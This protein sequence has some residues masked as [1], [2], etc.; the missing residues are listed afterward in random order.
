MAEYRL[1]K[2]IDLSDFKQYLG[3]DYYVSVKGVVYSSKYK[4]IL[5]GNLSNGY[6][7]FELLVN[8]KKV[9]KSQHRLIAE[10]F[11]PNP[12]N[13][14]LV[15]HLNDI[16]SDV[17]IKNLAWGTKSDNMK[18][19]VMNGLLKNRPSPRG[20]KNRNAKLNES[21]VVSIRNELNNGF[22]LSDIS[23]KYGVSWAVAYQIKNRLTW[24]HI[25]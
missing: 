16:K 1:L 11:I 3:S 8:G 2:D 14:P 7:W 24:K 4:R 12:N 6:L 21:Q 19:A 25:A 17:C 22:T 20:E 18:D 23:I 13:Y 5:R 15:R 10:C 9:N